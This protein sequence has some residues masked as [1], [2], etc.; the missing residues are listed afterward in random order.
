MHPAAVFLKYLKDQL[1]SVL[2]MWKTNVYKIFTN[3][4]SAVP[5]F[6][7]VYSDPALL[8]ENDRAVFI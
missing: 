8:K 1:Q 3:K 6:L 7:M 4:Y 5:A 2:R